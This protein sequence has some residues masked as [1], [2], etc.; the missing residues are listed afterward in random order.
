MKQRSLLFALSLLIVLALLAG[1]GAKKTESAL[2]RM[3]RFIPD[4]S[5][6]REYVVFGDAAAWHASWD[7]ARIDDLDE[8]DRLDREPRAYWMNIMSS[9]TIPANAL[10]FQ[11]L[12]SEDMRGSYGFDLLNVDRWI[13][14]G[15][16]PETM[17]AI[18]YGFSADKIA[19]ALEEAGYDDEKL[20]SGATL[21]SMFD[22][23]EAPFTD[24]PTRAG[25][26]GSLNRIAVLDGQM[27]ITRAT[28][29]AED[30]LDANS[31]DRRSLAE[32]KEFL[33]AALALQDKALA[34]YGELVGVF[35]TDDQALSDPA[36]YLDPRQSPEVLEELAQRYERDA[37]DLPGWELVAF[38][39]QHAVE[40]SYL[41]LLVVFD[42]GT[43]AEEA[44]EVL[45]DRLEDYELIQ[46]P[47]PLMDYCRCSLEP[48]TAVEAEGLP[49][50]LVT[51]RADNPPPT[52]EEELM[53]N[54][55]VFDWM[56]LVWQRDTGFLMSD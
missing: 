46:Q 26:T 45:A 39:T 6:Y 49:V 18:E 12:V 54:T 41:T 27:V 36:T 19:K 5:D 32:N 1:C 38:V 35:L 47:R 29:L 30:A 3:L 8:L 20:E 17:T 33:A 51:L 44:A 40:A 28:E 13:E 21:Y 2:L 25:M 14:A 43:D 53:V 55:F 23:Y 4:K 50:A 7:I 24:S 31:G 10:G 56:R 16:P 15:A 34:G 42:E 37:G 48:V 9:Q 52:P 22:D 11:Y